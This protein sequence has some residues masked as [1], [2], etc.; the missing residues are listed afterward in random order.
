M[1]IGSVAV[2]G[3][4][5]MGARIA[6]HIANAGLPV[7][8]LDVSESA[9]REGI[10]R[11]RRAK[12]DP[13]FSADSWN[14]LSTGSLDA[15]L[16]RLRSVDW[17]IEAVV[18]QADVKRDLLARVDAARR[19]GSIVSSN[20]SGIP[21]GSLAEGRSSDFRRHWLGTHFF[22]P[23]RYLHLL[24]VIP[25]PATDPGIVRYLCDF[26]DRRLGKGVVL[27]RDTPNFIGNR[28]GLY[29]L[30]RLLAAV[31]T[32]AFSIEEID[33]ITG[34]VLGRPKS[35]TFRTLDITGLDVVAHVASNLRRP[36][37]DAGENDAWR[38]PAFVTGMIERGL[39]GEKTGAG[40]Y[41]RVGQPHDAAEILTLDVTTFEYR[42]RQH[43]SLPS[44]D[45]VKPVA[46]VRER[47]RRLFESDDKAGQLLRLTLAPTLVYTARVAPDIAYSPGDVDRAMRWGFGWDLGP[48][49]LIEAVGAT[50]VV[51]AA[52]DSAPELVAAGVPP[53]LSELECG[54]AVA[55]S[56]DAGADAG[57]LLLHHARRRSG[58][59][60]TTPAASL[61]DLGDGVLSVEFHSKMNTV[62]DDTLAVLRE[63]LTEA[64]RNFV[65]LVVGSEAVHFSVGADLRLLLAAATESRWTRIDEMIRT[66]QQTTRA[67]R[68]AD[69]PV[70]VAAAGLTLG[71]GC[72]IALHG[73][74]IQAA[75]ETYMG[76]VE[77]GV[78]LIPAAGGTTEMVIRASDAAGGG[79]L[80]PPIRRAFET[81]AFARI[82]TSAADARHLGY[83]R[84]VDATTMNRERLVADAK[85]RALARVAD[86]Y[87]PPAPRD[88]IPVGGDTV[89][90]PLKLG[91]HLAWR[92]GRI[93][94]HDVLVART[95]A[96]V[97]AG[98]ALPHDTTVGERELLDLER[99][100]FLRLVGEPKTLDR[101]RHTLDTGKPLRN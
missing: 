53:L 39:I 2:L 12:P 47:V 54:N 76:L 65:A 28:I 100:A 13:A 68:Y 8:V 101:I 21:I 83:L 30:L 93:S 49:E 72:E 52:R 67:M 71:G 33:A 14:R 74:T 89:L 32:G 77:T 24:E 34:P 94:D 48:F 51:A 6:A 45:A 50:R 95:L 75:A 97:M 9:A 3:A 26:A 44:L 59:V 11:A 73:D 82:S 20:T 29:A 81:I 5:T 43:V 38:L 37:R 69:V 66:F 16:P 90:A 22:N 63:G 15:D 56:G 60:R 18:E 61:V 78:G 27:A 70:V 86:G 62:N 23:P 25:T 88:R 98:G 19:P 57:L 1:R 92:A 96:T 79:D 87:H 7:L 64:S 55:V 36:G 99:E 85:A 4:G 58:T 40:F 31:E 17:T 41:K 46:D 10:E 84:P 80:V 42:A 91:I 35:A